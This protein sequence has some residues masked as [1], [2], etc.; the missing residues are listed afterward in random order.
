MNKAVI[1]P[2]SQHEYI[3]LFSKFKGQKNVDLTIVS[4]TPLDIIVSRNIRSLDLSNCNVRHIKLTDPLPLNTLK[5]PINGGFEMFKSHFTMFNNVRHLDCGGCYVDHVPPNNTIVKLWGSNIKSMGIQYKL[6][7]LK[8]SG[9]PISEL[10][11]MGKLDCLVCDS[12]NITTLPNFKKLTFLLCFNTDIKI[13]PT[14]ICNTIKYCFMENKLLFES[15]PYRLV[16]AFDMEIGQH[17]LNQYQNAQLTQ[18]EF[19]IPFPIDIV[20]QFCIKK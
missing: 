20:K 6:E 12:T 9:S 5:L 14:S 16:E 13:I 17:Y 19:Q 10:P 15:V 8:L 4:T 7:E 2:S 11:L 1:N 18:D 3:E